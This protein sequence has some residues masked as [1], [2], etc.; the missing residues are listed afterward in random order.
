MFAVDLLAILNRHRNAVFDWNWI[1]LLGQPRKY[2]RY[3]SASR[4]YV[5]YRYIAWLVIASNLQTSAVVYPAVIFRRINYC[6]YISCHVLLVT[7]AGYTS[8]VLRLHD[9]HWPELLILSD[10]HFWD[11]FMEFKVIKL[12]DTLIAAMNSQH[13]WISTCSEG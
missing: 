13:L 11:F 10:K 5:N 6:L 9:K 4:C 12:F 7:W 3:P 8:A 1:R 2:K